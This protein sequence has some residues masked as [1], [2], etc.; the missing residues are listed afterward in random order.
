M[1]SCGRTCKHGHADLL[2]IEFTC[3]GNDILVDSGTYQYNKTPL[4]KYFRGTTAHNTVRLDGQD[5]SRQLR[6][7]SWLTCAEAE[8]M[9]NHI[10]QKIYL[11]AF[12]KKGKNSLPLHQRELLVSRNMT[13][14]E[15]LDTPLKAKCV[16]VFWHFDPDLELELEDKNSFSIIKS[17]LMLG[18]VNVQG[19]GL[20]ISVSTKETPYSNKYGCLDKQKTLCVEANTASN[21]RGSIKT[22]FILK[23]SMR[24]QQCKQQNK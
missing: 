5:Q 2:A 6:N 7:F 16:E 20:E 17:G 8:I 14:I 19:E 3:E 13:T 4:R 22:S 21:K 15:C 1:I 24:S 9:E 10:N 12:L 11:K 23:R 18:R